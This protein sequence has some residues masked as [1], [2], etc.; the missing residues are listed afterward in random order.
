MQQ[1]G[2]PRPGVPR[3]GLVVQ[4]GR[5][6]VHGAGPGQ[7]PGFGSRPPMVSHVGDDGMAR[8]TPAR[9]FGGS[10]AEEH[11]LVPHQAWRDGQQ[12]RPQPQRLGADVPV[13]P[14]AYPGMDQLAQE[15]VGQVPQGSGHP[16]LAIV[17]GN[18]HPQLVPTMGQQGDEFA[19]LRE[20]VPQTWTLS[21]QMFMRRHKKVSG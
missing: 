12:P 3:P 17:P 11:G 18:H 10:Y 8:I 15:A 21:P 6:L 4:P 14:P 7:R 2:A 19:P 1:F 5:G 9:F 20:A 16:Q 13:P